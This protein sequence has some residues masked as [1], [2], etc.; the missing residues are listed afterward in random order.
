MRNKKYALVDFAFFDRTGIQN[1]LEKQAKKGW[2]LKDAAGIPWIFERIEPQRLRFSVVYFPAESSGDG[3]SEEKRQIFMEYCR[4]S[5]WE[6]AAVRG[7]MFIW[8]HKSEDPV[9]I[10]TDPVL[11]LETIHK[12]VKK[13]HLLSRWIGLVGGFPTM[14]MVVF[15]LFFVLCKTSALLTSPFF[16]LMLYCTIKGMWNGFELLH[17]YRWRKRAMLAAQSD[18][19]FVDTRSYPFVNGILF[20]LL[21]LTFA[22]YFIG[23]F[24]IPW[25]VALVVIPI[26]LVC[27]VLMR[28]LLYDGGKNEEGS[29]WQL[30]LIMLTVMLAVIAFAVTVA[31]ALVSDWG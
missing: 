17:Y 9:P 1:F 5:G 28:V 31:F 18:G 27:P 14:L 30:L 25:L 26:Y 12:T 11:E 22:L 19:S 13:E 23:T 21:V 2:L 7:S 6:L 20:M 24:D 4:H 16:Y 10:E 29:V 15:V 3:D 8:Y